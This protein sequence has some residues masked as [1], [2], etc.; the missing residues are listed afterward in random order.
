MENVVN[1]NSPSALE[2]EQE[3]IPTTTPSPSNE[4]SSRSEV[5]GWRSVKFIIGKIYMF[6]KINY[7]NPSYKHYFSFSTTLF[8]YCIDSLIIIF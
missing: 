5:G 3:R 8:N 7:I 6:S 2:L 4:I 1:T